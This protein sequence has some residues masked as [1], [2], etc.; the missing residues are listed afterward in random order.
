MIQAHKLAKDWRCDPKR[1]LEDMTECL[2]LGREGEP[3][4]LQADEFS[5]QDLAAHFILED[6]RPIGL[7]GVKRLY[8]PEGSP[9]DISEAT[10]GVHSSAF[11]NIT[12]QI[13][14]S[15]ILQGYMSEDFVV[16]RMVST[17]PTSLKGE[18]IPGINKLTDPGQDSLVV[19][20][21]EEYATQGFGENWIETPVP[22]KRGRIVPV[23][24]E[25]IFFDRTNLVLS[26]ASQVGELIGTNKEKR[27]LDMVI[28]GAKT[29]NRNG[30]AYWTYYGLAD[31][32]TAPY[33]N[34]LD[35]NELIDWT[36]IN[37][38][39]TLFAKLTDPDTG[40]PIIMTGR[41]L[42]IG[43]QLRMT[44]NRILTATNTRTGT[45]PVVEAANPLAT[46]GISTFV[47]RLLYARLIATDT[48]GHS[49]S[50]TNAA[51]YYW[52]G[53]FKKAFAYMQNWALTTSRAPTNSEAEFSQDIVARFKASE[54]GAAAV[55][56]PRA[57]TRSRAVTGSSSS[58]GA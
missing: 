8:N 17:I 37:N 13:V 19:D 12:G 22:F 43:P 11:A 7:E 56:E 42:L 40:E 34:H 4:G 30:T 52:Y 55:L 16:S 44:A 9:M 33:V 50:A 35:A 47:S 3:G 25:A 18:K 1:T 54:M 5:V 23:T 26:R 31:A 38:L 14:F 57:I 45:N 2:R 58:S 49:E 51:G 29:Y 20:E 21:G 27:L 32:S 15:R 10:G 24:K 53:D 28:G 41:Q 39:E 48:Y 46:M 36:D 6:D